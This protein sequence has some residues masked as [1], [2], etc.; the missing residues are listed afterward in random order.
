VFECCFRLS[1]GETDLDLEAA[2]ERVLI[3]RMADSAA[4]LMGPK[5]FRVSLLYKKV[6]L[7]FVNLLKYDLI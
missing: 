6:V 5:R 4:S 3:L 2:E 7:F 1:R